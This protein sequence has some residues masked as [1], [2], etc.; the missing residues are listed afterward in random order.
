VPDIFGRILNLICI[1]FFSDTLSDD[2]PDDPRGRKN[3]FLL[4][5][6]R[7]QNILHLEFDQCPRS[8]HREL[9]NRFFDWFHQIEKLE[10]QNQYYSKLSFFTNIFYL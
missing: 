1:I 4:S 3:K 2:S 8:V 7:N 6:D 9:R 5:K 10:H